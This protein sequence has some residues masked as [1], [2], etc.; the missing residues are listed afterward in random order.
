ERQVGRAERQG[1]VFSQRTLH[2]KAT[3]DVDGPSYPHLLLNLDGR[4]VDGLLECLLIGDRTAELS[5]VVV[6]FPWFAALSGRRVLDRRILDERS[7]RHTGFDCRDVDERFERRTGLTSSLDGA[8]EFTLEEVI[9]ADHRLDVPGLGIEREE[10]ALGA[11]DRPLR[12]G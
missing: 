11:L 12:H 9:A 3:S 5:V 1:E 10:R 4:D 6:G 7:R 2:T 8:V